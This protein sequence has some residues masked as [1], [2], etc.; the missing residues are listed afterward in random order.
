MLAA[1]QRAPAA[2]ASRA[3]LAL[4]QQSHSAFSSASSPDEDYSLVLRKA[5]EVS[6]MRSTNLPKV[7]TGFTFGVPLE[8][9]KRTVCAICLGFGCLCA[10]SAGRFAYTQDAVLWG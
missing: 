3:L 1:L 7:E 5:F 4:Q 10:L 6:V 8:T 2:A 9:F